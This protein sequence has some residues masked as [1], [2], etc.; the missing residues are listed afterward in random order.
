MSA[1]E[2]PPGVGA[3]WL[4]RL[5]LHRP[6]LR[7]W[8]MYD[9]AISA[10]ET[11]I[12]VAVFPIFFASVATSAG[13]SGSQAEQYLAYA[14]SAATMIIALLSP[15]L[16]AIADYAAMK[17][18]L[19]AAFMSMG[20]IAVASMWLIGRGD[21]VLGI[22]LFVLANIG[23]GG[24]RVFY[25]AL[26]PHIASEK[27]IDRVSTAGYAMGYVGGGVLLALNLAWTLRPG[28]FGLP[29]G[30]DL[31]PAQATLPA[32]LALV[33][34]A[35]WWLVFSI[36]LFRRVPEPSVRLDPEER[37]GQNPVR[38]GF[39]RLYDTLR[40]LR[41]YRQA[42]VMLLAFLIYND[43]IG[44]IQKMATI[45]G[46]ELG[47]P[48]GSLVTAILIVQFV[49]IPFSFLFGPL[50]GW[51]GAKRAI[52]VGLF[53]YMGVSVFGFRMRTATDFYILALLVGMVQGGTQAL[54]RSLFA[55][56]I[57][58]HKSGEFFGFFSIFSRFA[59]TFGPLVFGIVVGQTGS[60]R[61][62]ILSIIGFFIVGAAILYFVDV[63]EG[64]RVARAAEREARPASAGEVG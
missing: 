63:E 26:L 23:A 8:A 15:I 51:I 30:P 10:Q 25:D 45:Y 11:T 61:N 53:V 17:K 38:E 7:A 24:S 46:H 3:G 12:A 6:E 22:T 13:L 19:L 57:P 29:S 32:R 64:E 28:W 60:S 50:A 27:E 55:V 9:W 35:V 44:T 43:G 1:A 42:F 33:S 36:Q 59:A 4:A 20:V 58:Q 21:V 56:M 54:S 62:A 31:T 34:V 48:T 47:I 16:G 39:I 41:L 2:T 52:F 18:R 37:L 14:N 5:G 40:E 49:G